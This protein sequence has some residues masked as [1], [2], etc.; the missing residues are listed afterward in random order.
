M[1]AV[2]CCSA[3][4]REEMPELPPWWLPVLPRGPPGRKTGCR[5]KSD[6][7][8]TDRRV[9]PEAKDKD[10]GKGDSPPPA[11]TASLPLLLPAPPSQAAIIDD[12]VDPKIRVPEGAAA[13]KNR[14]VRFTKRSSA[15]TTGAQRPPVSPTSPATCN[16]VRSLRATKMATASG[17]QSPLSIGSQAEFGTP[18]R[19]PSPQ[20]ESEND[21]VPIEIEDG[22]EVI[23]VEGEDDGAEI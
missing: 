17:S 7:A 1:R 23:E 9:E 8:A 11:A 4:A 10:A 22:D 14:R 5:G 15:A 20:V 3:P 6:A 12:P 2:E 13:V 19:S 16:I 21:S 18:S